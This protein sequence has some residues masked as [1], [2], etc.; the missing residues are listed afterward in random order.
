MITTR[1]TGDRIRLIGSPDSRK[2]PRMTEKNSD[3]RT[4]SEV[5]QD[6][7][8]EARPKGRTLG[9]LL[10]FFVLLIIVG[11]LIGSYKIGLMESVIRSTGFVGFGDRLDPVFTRP[12]DNNVVSSGNLL[13]GVGKIPGNDS[14]IGA[15][16]VLGSLSADG[17]TEKTMASPMASDGAN[18]RQWNRTRAEEKF[19]RDP[20][21]TSEVSGSPVSPRPVETSVMAS[22]KASHPGESSLSKQTAAN[23][24]GQKGTPDWEEATRSD[25][26]RLPGSLL[27]K[28][29]NYSGNHVNWGIAVI[30][31]NSMSMAR[32]SKILTPNR[33]K[34][35]SEF[36][37]K[38]PGVLTPNS[39]LIIRDFSCG[40]SDD[41]EKKSPCVTHVLLDWAGHPYKQLKEV[42]ERTHAG[43]QTDPCA[44]AAYAAKTDFKGQGNLTPR[45]LIVT[46]GVSKCA[47]SAV[48]KAIEVNESKDKI[49]V[50]V[51][52]LGMGKKRHG[53]YAALVNKTKGILMDVEKP[54]DIDQAVS[55]YAKLLK[56]KVMEKVEIKGD[57]AITTVSPFQE[58]A[59]TPGTYTVVLPLVEALN[60]SKR[61]IEGVKISPGETNVM[62]VTIRKGTPI[63][64]AGHK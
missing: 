12:S 37:G 43:R 3:D 61:T 53:G 58:I 30:F 24:A 50:D 41:S 60:P 34:L 11:G 55:R 26:F 9:P 22:G 49:A 52:A 32:Q 14:G 4:S 20:S 46:N 25:Q 5:R 21:T 1:F 44:A 16:Q 6:P 47:A 63:I 8:M 29:H 64:R 18:D 54:A 40:K 39:K 19:P 31:D 56:A 28:I 45:I 15:G 33:L 48:V 36:V 13:A 10:I 38:L 62:E 2:G 42:L 57:K 27:V 7:S 59:L 17:A 23:P 35:A 51:L